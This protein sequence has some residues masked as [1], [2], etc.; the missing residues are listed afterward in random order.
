MRLQHTRR[1]E[2]HFDDV[3]RAVQCRDRGKSSSSQSLSSSARRAIQKPRRVRLEECALRVR[4]RGTEHP[5]DSQPLLVGLSA[6][7]DQSFLATHTPGIRKLCV[8][9]RRKA[10]KADRR[11][12]LCIASAVPL[13]PPLVASSSRLQSC[14]SA[15]REPAI[16]VK[17]HQPE[18][19]KGYRKRARSVVRQSSGFIGGKRLKEA[20]EEYADGDISIATKLQHLQYQ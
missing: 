5:D 10:L 16:K 17:T 8:S 3:E 9:Y 19:C 20:A 15:T 12:M 18:R 2:T 4:L 7:R 14:K 13:V 6:L 11:S 1:H